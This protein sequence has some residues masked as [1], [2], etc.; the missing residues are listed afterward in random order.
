MPNGRQEAQESQKRKGVVRCLRFLRIFAANS[1][2]VLNSFSRAAACLVIAG[3]LAV[4]T[5]SS[6]SAQTALNKIA[7]ARD[8]LRADRT[9]VVAEAMVLS[10]VEAKAF[11]PLYREYRAA[12]DTITDG[13]MKL[14]LEYSDVYP[15]VPE[16]RAESMLKE[17]TA[18]EKKFVEARA[19]HLKRF[20][21]I[22]TPVKALRLAQV[23]NRL[24]LAVRTQLANVI[25]LVPTQAKD[26]R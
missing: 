5:A 20:A 21:K 1:P 11:W 22:I 26:G 15:N 8:D 19:A 12:M 2:L 18:L 3:L 9:A 16:D 4:V 23:E 17:Y 24:D 7:V 13:L 25:P 10:E 14:V 6:G